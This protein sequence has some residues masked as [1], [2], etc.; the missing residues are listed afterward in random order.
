MKKISLVLATA[1]TLFVFPFQNFA[2]SS[3]DTENKLSLGFKV[4]ANLS[5]VYD[6]QGDQFQADPRF[7]LAGGAFLSIP[8]TTYIGIQPELLFSQRGFQGSGSILGST[9]SYSKTSNYIDVPILIALKVSQNLSF[10]IGPQYSY[11][12]SQKYVFNSA[13][14]NTQQEDQFNNENIRKNTLCITGGADF[15]FDRLVLGARIGLD[16]L[17]NNGDGT[18]DTPRYKNMWYQATIGYRF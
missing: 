9:Y 6:T 18:N 15:S 14:I 16:V 11:L 10:L 4:G 2:Q 3:S 17:N 13:I 1:I 7:G 8:I 12:I 5:N